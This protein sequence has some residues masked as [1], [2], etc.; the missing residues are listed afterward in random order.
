M[1]TKQKTHKTKGR[2]D[3]AAAWRE[4]I[5]T[6]CA[7]ISRC[8]EAPGIDAETRA[9]A[10]LALA[11][12]RDDLSPDDP[13]LPEFRPYTL[14]LAHGTVRL[15]RERPGTDRHDALLSLAERALDNAEER[16]SQ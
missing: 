3:P 8:L 1:N 15:L 10:R 14:A 5:L 7:A 16:E 9:L 6:A 4:A 13:L 2:A 12:L 11:G